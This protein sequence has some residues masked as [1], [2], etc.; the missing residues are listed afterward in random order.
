METKILSSMH[1]LLVKRKENKGQN[2]HYRCNPNGVKLKNTEL[3][4]IDSNSDSHSH[5]H[6]NFD[7]NPNPYYE[8]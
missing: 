7:A 4:N 3:Y 5:S 1:V 2:P 8:H 6:S